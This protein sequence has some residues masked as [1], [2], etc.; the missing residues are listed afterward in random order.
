[1]G[2]PVF[3]KIPIPAHRDVRPGD[4]VMQLDGMLRPVPAHLL[5]MFRS[6]DKPVPR[7]FK[8]LSD[9]VMV[10]EKHAE[11]VTVTKIRQRRRELEQ[12]TEK[13][14]PAE[15]VRSPLQDLPDK[16]VMAFM[17][18]EFEE[19]FAPEGIPDEPELLPVAEDI[20]DEITEPMGS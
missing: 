6:M 5:D 13:A 10:V 3:R 18:A 4:Y 14:K 11:E 15:R 2:K 12:K 16:D 7:V 9:G 8:L 17:R 1:M 19:I 20:E